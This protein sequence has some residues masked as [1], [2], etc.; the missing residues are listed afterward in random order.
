MI[1]LVL[2]C[3]AN[4]FKLVINNNIPKKN[5]KIKNL[6]VDFKAANFR[7]TLNQPINRITEID[8]GKLT[9]TIRKRLASDK[10]RV[11]LISMVVEMNGAEE[12]IA[13]FFKF[14][15]QPTNNV[16]KIIINLDSAKSASGIVYNLENEVKDHNGFL[17]FQKIILKMY[18]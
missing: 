3:N 14:N 13:G 1:L 5:M 6:T 18:F 10:N 16:D 7:Q 17:N 12:R 11:M 4:A 15:D 2:S 9:K 8:L